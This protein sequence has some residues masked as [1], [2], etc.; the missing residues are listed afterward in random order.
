[1]ITHF[2]PKKPHR[3]R[4]ASASLAFRSRSPLTVYRTTLSVHRSSHTV[5]RASHTA[6]RSSLKPST[7]SV[8]D[9]TDQQNMRSTVDLQV[10]KLHSITNVLF[11]S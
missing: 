6:H 2:F 1:M 3:L 8:I 4:T 10:H 5:Y 11:R 7:V 9:I